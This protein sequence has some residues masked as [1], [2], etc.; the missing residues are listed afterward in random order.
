MIILG[1][2]D[3]DLA[4]VAADR[5]DE[6]PYDVNPEVVKNVKGIYDN[7]CRQLGSSS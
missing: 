7:L 1:S 5:R 3:Y 2:I 4:I 6:A